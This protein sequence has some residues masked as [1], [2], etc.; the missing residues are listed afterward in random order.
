MV[1][2]HFSK[3][4]ALLK[5]DTRSEAV[6][7]PRKAIVLSADLLGL[8]S[9]VCNVSDEHGVTRLLN[10]LDCFVEQFSAINYEDKES[11][12]FFAKKYWAF[13]DGIVICWYSGSDAQSTMTEFDAD[14]D[15]LSGIGAAQAQIMLEN[16]QLVSGGI[17]S[18]WIVERNTTVSG[19]ALVEAARIEKKIKMPFIGVEQSLYDFYKNHPGRGFYS[20]DFDPIPEIFIPPCNYTRN[21]PAL[22]YLMIG[23]AQ[24]DLTDSQIRQSKGIAGGEAQQQFR[25]ECWSKNRLSFIEQHKTLV[26]E[27]LRHS[28]REV[29][30]K[31]DALRRHHNFRV[32]ELYTDSADLLVSD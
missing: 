26:T 9:E 10:R 5:D 1:H 19:T 12:E 24:V 4:T 31:Y 16:R 21:Y 14:L 2:Q 3:D 8:S 23:L 28:D 29:R 32:S 13:S 7:E 25:N 6:G 18:G 20:K 11:Q 30:D 15:Q 17:G 22:D 27:G